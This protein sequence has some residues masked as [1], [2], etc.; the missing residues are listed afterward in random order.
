MRLPLAV[1]LAL[2]LLGCTTLEPVV[3]SGIDLQQRLSTE[4][5]VK[6]GD[7]V[8]VRTVDGTVH[9]LTVVS[10]GA[11]ELVGDRETIAIDQIASVSKQQLNARRTTTL[12]EA[13]VLAV[14]VGLA[15]AGLHSGVGY[16]A[17]P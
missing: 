2:C 11:A 4:G 7:R 6:P 13:M 3:G 17:G 5:L 16:P 12:A 10:V 15:A 9:R 8:E 1:L 14:L